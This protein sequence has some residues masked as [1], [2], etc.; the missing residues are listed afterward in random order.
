MDYC[1]IIMI[2]LHKNTYKILVGMGILAAIDLLTHSL[3]AVLLYVSVWSILL[4]RKSDSVS[5][6]SGITSPVSGK[7]TSVSKIRMNEADLVCVT[8][9]TLPVIDPQNFRSIPSDKIISFKIEAKTKVIDYES[10]VIVSHSPV[11]GLA[12]FELDHGNLQNF[13]YDNDD[14]NYGYSIL[15]CKTNVILPKGYVSYLTQ[16]QK[17]INGETIVGGA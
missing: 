7:V 13:Q 9:D 8:I 4:F 2:S 5:R 3:W 11:M 10:G 16:G 6:S 17:V 12:S 14:N 1:I 15:G